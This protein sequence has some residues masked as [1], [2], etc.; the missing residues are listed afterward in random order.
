M[1]G[2]AEMP[3]QVLGSRFFVGGLVLLKKG[4]CY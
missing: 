1:I 2:V 3:T 4:S